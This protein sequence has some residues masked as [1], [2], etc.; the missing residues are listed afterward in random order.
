MKMLKT[1]AEWLWRR[2]TAVLYGMT[3]VLLAIIFCLDILTPVSITL[4]ILYIVPVILVGVWSSPHAILA[5]TV[6]GGVGTVLGTAAYFLAPTTL[7]HDDVAVANRALALFGLWLS[8][9]IILLRKGFEQDREI[10]TVLERT[11]QRSLES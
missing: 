2:S 7:H 9:V 10:R 1:P 6:V 3:G 11:L 5:V 8:V 4:P